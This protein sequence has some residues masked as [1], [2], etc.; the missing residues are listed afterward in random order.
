MHTA[1]YFAT[2]A[3]S[4][5]ATLA[6]AADPAACAPAAHPALAR[7]ACAA[8]AGINANTFIVLPPASTR[9]VAGHANH[10]HPAV[11]VARQTRGVDS[12][13]FLVQP[14]VAVTWTVPEPEATRM[15]AAT[16]AAAVVR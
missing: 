10:D 12:N 7:S 13:T 6:Q 11:V 14:P 9:W 3:L 5:A 16:P 1:R 4:F 2:V 8:P 15:L